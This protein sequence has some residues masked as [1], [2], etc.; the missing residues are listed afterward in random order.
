MPAFS[1]D[2]TT[3]CENGATP[4]NSNLPPEVA[5]SDYAINGGVGAGWDDGAGGT[6]GKP[7]DWCLKGSTN[8]ITG[9]SS[10]AAYPDCD[11]HKGKEGSEAVTKYWNQNFN[12]ISGWRTAARIGQVVDGASKTVLVGE[13]LMQPYFYEHSCPFTD[14]GTNVSHGNGGDNSSMYQG[15]DIDTSRTAGLKQDYNADPVTAGVGNIFG[16]PHTGAANIAFCDGSVRSIS[17]DVEDFAEMVR[18]ND[19]D[20]L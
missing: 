17:Y 9:E 16:G 5:K 14:Q 18:R 10:P 12:G 3:S 6:G 8:G 15:W 7:S 2:G 19:A 4:K 11:W 20:E 1:P 13:K